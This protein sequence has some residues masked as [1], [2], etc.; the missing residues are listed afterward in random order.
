MEKKS[1][2]VV[3][4]MLSF[5]SLLSLSVSNANKKAESRNGS[6][7]EE[8]FGEE[9][10]IMMESEISRRIMEEQNK[11][12][13]SPGALKRDQPVC[14]QGSSGQSYSSTCLPPPSNPHTR[15]CSKYYHCRSDS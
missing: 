2:V 1:L 11:K 8:W 15:G 5:L 6:I 10:E 4:G 9:E 12:Y 3:V 14:N 7:H 13:I